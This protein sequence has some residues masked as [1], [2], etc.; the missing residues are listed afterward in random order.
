MEASATAGL[1]D[2][3]KALN[4]LKDALGPMYDEH[5]KGLMGV[6]TAVPMVT[7][8]LSLLLILDGRNQVPQ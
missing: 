7:N 3:L 4:L 6:L 5:K 2:K 8:N 1:V